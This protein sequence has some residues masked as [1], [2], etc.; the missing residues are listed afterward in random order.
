ME[1]VCRSEQRQRRRKNLK[2]LLRPRHIAF[3]GGRHIE[4]SIDVCRRV[5]FDGAIWPVNPKHKEL[6]G[7][8][9]FASI[10]DLPA[11]PDAALLAISPER[12][13]TA[14]RSLSAGGGG[15]AVCFANGF[16]E[17]NPEGAALQRELAAAAG[18]LALV[19]P[20]CMGVMNM[21]DNAAVWA[22]ENYLEHTDGCGAAIVSQS[23]AFLYGITN[24][25][26][27]FP[28]GYAI[29]SGNQ[30]V[31][32]ASDYIEVLLDDER[33]RAIGL[34]LEGLSDGPALAM[35]C[36][37]ALECLVPI[38]V[39]KGGNS[40]AGADAAVSHTGSLT[41]NEDLWRAFVERFGLIH[42]ETPKAMV[43]T[44]KMLTVGGVPAGHRIAVASYSGG[45]NSLLADR[46]PRLGL[47]TPAP[48]PAVHEALTAM[49]PKTAV[50]ANPFDVNLAWSSA[51]TVSIDDQAG[52]TACFVKF[53]YEQTDML[54]FF[55]DIPQPDEGIEGTWLPTVDAM[56]DARARTRLPCAVISILPEGL[57]PAIRARLLAGGV[58]PL[59][60]M[61]DGLE[62]IAAAARYRDQRTLIMECADTGE[63][64][65]RHDGTGPQ[66]ARILDEWESKQR[67]AACGLA[68]PEGWAGLREDAAVAAEDV[69]FPVAVK[70]L[71]E[72][73][74][75]K[76]R[77][78][79]VMLNLN[80]RSAVADAVAT[81]NAA[82]MANLPGTY[83]KRFLVEPMAERIIGYVVGEF[84]IGI[85]RHPAIGL[86][87]VVGRG[88]ADVEIARDFVTILLPTEERRIRR[89]LSTL[90]A[91]RC[92]ARPEYAVDALTAAAVAVA[93][94]AEQHRDTL[95]ELDVNPLMVGRDGRAVAADALIVLGTCTM[96]EPDSG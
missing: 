82:V 49:L 65:S 9:C 50:V 92:L 24:V 1:Q 88:G 77:A 43:E 27:G 70:V 30:A 61:Q 15:G 25:E 54:A 10:A 62:A 7:V 21:F 19:G 86:V 94:F 17:L 96:G 89:R 18:D 39:L 40:D 41:V 69:G 51:D 11:T 29:S 83:A 47:E 79:G 78:G 45:L 60:G 52:L 44:L 90:L 16:A 5:G 13:V 37:R 36:R 57:A 26:R 71:S 81:I 56:I 66:G 8:S 53:A 3:L 48:S 20:N 84:L 63:L 80:D 64:L 58:A 59:L 42:V 75:H 4:V 33:V 76:R 34:H 32:D 68:V 28:L 2:R 12:T 23:G 55:L 31:L 91:V 22:S 35:A 85:K 72:N 73:I 38:V 74:A 6:A 87:L 14:V 46:A 93:R 67:L 95:V